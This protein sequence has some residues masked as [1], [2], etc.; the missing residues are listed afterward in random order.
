M[1]RITLASLDLFHIINQA[2]YLQKVGALRGYY[3]TRLRPDVE[4]S[5]RNWRTVVIPPT[6]PCASGK[7]ICNRSMIKPM[8]ASAAD[9]TM[10]VLR[11]SIIRRSQA[12]W[13]S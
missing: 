6:M 5:C 10:M 3:T 12:A 7:C 2:Q 13:Q 4:K 9:P 11:E 1:P 8:A